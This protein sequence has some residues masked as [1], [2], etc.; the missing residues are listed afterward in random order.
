MKRFI[1]LLLG[2]TTYLLP[3]IGQ[4]SPCTAVDIGCTNPMISG[5]ASSAPY[6]GLVPSANY[7]ICNPLGNA[8]TLFYKVTITSQGIFTFLIR[9]GSDNNSNGV[10]DYPTE[11]TPIDFDWAVWLNTPCNSLLTIPP[12]RLSYDSPPPH[13]TGL[14]T[15]PAGGTCEGSNGTGLLDGIQV[16][17]NDVLIIAVNFFSGNGQ[18]PN[19]QLAVGGTY[20][21]GGNAGYTGLPYSLA[22]ETGSPKTSFCL[23]EDVMLNGAG[24]ISAN[25]KL[26]LLPATGNTPLATHE[27]STGSPNSINVTKIFRD[28]EGFNFQTGI[29]YRVKLLVK[30]PCGCFETIRTFKYECCPSSFKP[31]F[32]IQSSNGIING[33]SGA[34]GNHTWEV[35]QTSTFE[36][37]VLSA[38]GTYHETNLSQDLGAGSCYLI[39]HTVNNQCGTGCAA[40]RFCSL[41]CEDRECNLGVPD[42]IN[43][44]PVS[45]NL[46][47]NAV[48]NALNYVVV[49]TVDGCCGAQ[50]NY[51]NTATLTPATNFCSLNP[52]S[53]VP[54]PPRSIQCLNI[55]IYAVC[56][57]GTKSAVSTLCYYYG[58]SKENPNNNLTG[59]SENNILNDNLSIYPNPASQHVTLDFGLAARGE[60]YFEIY[61][62][63]GQIIEKAQPLV[64]TN[65]KN[66]VQINTARYSKGV[67]NLKLVDASGQVLIKKL[68]IE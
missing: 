24:A 52:F 56:P 41:N 5:D 9:P 57:Y 34:T 20:G 28:L 15:P 26:E 60:M 42:N 59:I 39:R 3:L 18:I 7:N 27:V 4:N 58:S 49:V 54:N 29:N 47:W 19:F 14:V 68:V 37:N 17:V 2:L 53:L 22:D 21:G 32:T 10:I 63:I 25:Y 43:Y 1:L 33:I 6:F 44:D 46:S 30:G 31:D 66:S 38:L 61:N 35:F 16:N 12:V 36:D 40:Q 45:F 67:Y 64:I 65:G 51:L 13:I 23:G 62:S 55:T 8:P 48:P 11:V 50:S